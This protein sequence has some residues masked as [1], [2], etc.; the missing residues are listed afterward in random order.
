[1]KAG[2]SESACYALTLYDLNAVTLLAA[3][4]VEAASAARHLVL[5]KLLDLD[6]WVTSL[7]PLD[8]P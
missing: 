5:A 3:D 8:C 2:R 6:E 7:S 1:M 4:G